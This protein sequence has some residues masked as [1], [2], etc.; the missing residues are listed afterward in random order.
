VRGFGAT[1]RRTTFFAGRVARAFAFRAFR[2][3]FCARRILRAFAPTRFRARAAARRARD[4]PD[5]RGFLRFRRGRARLPAA[6]RILSILRRSRSAA[7]SSFARRRTSGA[8]SAWRRLTAS[9]R[10]NCLTVSRFTP[11]M[12]V[13]LH[14]SRRAGLSR[15]HYAA[16]A[17][18]VSRFI[19][20]DP[21]RSP[22]AFCILKSQFDRSWPP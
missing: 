8:A 6:D 7:A 20:F 22:L 5:F 15:I 4:F 11:F 17:K 10:S 14:G 1:G 12:A 21:S 13:P 19:P 3:G 2:T 9:I 18:G 16:R